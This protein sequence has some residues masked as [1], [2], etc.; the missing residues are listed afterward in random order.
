MHWQFWVLYCWCSLGWFHG[1]ALRLLLAYTFLWVSSLKRRCSQKHLPAGYKI[2]GRQKYARNVLYSYH[3]ARTSSRRAKA[4]LNKAEHNYSYKDFSRTDSYGANFSYCQFYG[5]RFEKAS[6][7]NCQFVGSTFTAVTFKNCIIKFSSFNDAFFINCLFENCKIEKTSFSRSK[8]HST[9]FKNCGK[10]FSTF[11][12]L[13]IDNYSGQQRDQLYQ[14]ANAKTK[15]VLDND[16]TLCRLFNAYSFNNMID[17]IRLLDSKTVK[18]VTFS[19]IVKFIE[20]AKNQRTKNKPWPRLIR[21]KLWLL[22][23]A[24]VVV[25]SYYS[26]LLKRIPF[27]PEGGPAGCF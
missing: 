22:D 21:N 16:E 12:Q 8:M 15:R 5:T 10:R 23:T 11:P 7:K 6:L 14:Y 27:F 24:W 25:V 3:S 1:C 13:P 20:E 19:H 9:F 18:R 26:D 4:V 17:G 2:K